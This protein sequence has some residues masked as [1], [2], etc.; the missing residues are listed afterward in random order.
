MLLEIFHP[1]IKQ[2][3]MLA[4]MDDKKIEMP[5]ILVFINN[6]KYWKLKEGP[7]QPCLSSSIEWQC[8]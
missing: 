6:R 7:F 1:H 2:L 3:C 8:M 5:Y 4:P